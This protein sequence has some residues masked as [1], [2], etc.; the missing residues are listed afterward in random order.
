M[1][2]YAIG[3][4]P[5]I[6][7]RRV[8]QMAALGATLQEIGDEIGVTRER[9]RQILRAL[10]ITGADLRAIRRKSA[11]ETDRL[12]RE[13]VL[14][15]ARVN[16]GRTIAE[17]AA[18]INL[19]EVR[20]REVLKAGEAQRFFAAP[21][22]VYE[23]RFTDQ[24]I[25]EAIRAAA[26]VHGSPLSHD[27]YDAWARGRNAATVV[28]I[29]QRFGTWSAACREA[30]VEAHTPART[31]TRRWTAGQMLDAAIDYFASPGA[32]YTY[33]DFDRWLRTQASLPSA[34]TIRNQFGSWATVKA[35][36]MDAQP[37]HAA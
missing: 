11:A 6:R 4:T 32:T 3:K 30:G 15:W 34:Q 14:A 21:R 27:K 17:A 33:D 7:E 2:H 16:T 37:P 28:R 24:Q 23:P 19:P 36:A 5:T 22:R 1:H 18:S 29:T 12:D 35:A 10:D 26:Y 25:C 9:A 8:L 31:Y 20:I 13:T